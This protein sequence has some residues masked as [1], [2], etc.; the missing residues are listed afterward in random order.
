MK[1]KMALDERGHGR[2]WLMF[3]L[4]NNIDLCIQEHNY[5]GCIYG[6][7]G[8]SCCPNDYEVEV[9]FNTCAWLK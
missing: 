4:L 9:L 1:A 5:N 7:G 3:G 6:G 2:M 8:K